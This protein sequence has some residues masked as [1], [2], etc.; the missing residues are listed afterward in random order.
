M[1]SRELYKFR[2]I[3]EIWDVIEEEYNSFPE[4]YRQEKVKR[5]TSKE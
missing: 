2:D 5:G 4:K 1:P 3:H